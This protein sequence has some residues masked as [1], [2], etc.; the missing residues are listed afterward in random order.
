MDG[1]WLE[2]SSL[3]EKK[4]T[5]SSFVKLVVG[6]AAGVLALVGLAAVMVCVAV[7]YRRRRRRNYKK[8]PLH[9]EE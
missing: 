8:I 4:A 5:P 2:F 3:N 1:S 6:V 7:I 9:T